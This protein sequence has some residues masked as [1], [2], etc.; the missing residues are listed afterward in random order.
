MKINTMTGNHQNPT[1]RG[2]S[3][4]GALVHIQNHQTTKTSI[5]KNVNFDAI[6]FG[7]LHES[8]T[9]SDPTAPESNM[10][11]WTFTH[12]CDHA[13]NASPAF[14]Q[15]AINFASQLNLAR[16]LIVDGE[17]RAEAAPR[18]I[19][20]RA[21][22]DALDADWQSQVPEKL[23][24]TPKLQKLSAD[25]F[26]LLGQ[27]A[28][29]DP[30]HDSSAADRFVGFNP[31]SLDSVYVEALSLWT[32][33]YSRAA[34]HTDPIVEAA[35]RALNR[36]PPPPPQRL[37]LVHGLGPCGGVLFGP[38]NEPMTLVNWHFAHLGHPAEDLAWALSKSVRLG[39]PNGGASHLQTAEAIALWEYESGYSVDPNT[40]AWWQ[41]FASLKAITLATQQLQ[42][43][44]TGDNGLSPTHAV[45]ATRTLANERAALAVRVQNY[46]VTTASR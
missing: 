17:E 6:W 33:I 4:T 36:A 8:F 16:S 9:T 41:I 27:L 35:I 38:K 26:C 14:I 40:L 24:D 15:T 11:H 5:D 3:D 1:H 7:R 25:L 20:P 30:L 10:E 19:L 32:D 2:S 13:A 46:T 22:V 31:P 45:W 12:Q 39:G 37:A 44:R 28:R 34:Q 23:H 21:F 43:A 18:S 42:R 29:H